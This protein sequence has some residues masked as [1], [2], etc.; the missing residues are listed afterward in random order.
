M[1][2]CKRRRRATPVQAA[3][4]VALDIIAEVNL[5]S[6]QVTGALAKNTPAPG[7]V[8]RVSKAG[9]PAKPYGENVVA[10]LDAHSLS[11]LIFNDGKVVLS[12]DGHEVM[13]TN[14]A[15]EFK[16]AQE[17]IRDV[18]SEKFA[19][20]ITVDQAREMNA[21]D[22]T[23]PVPPGAAGSDIVEVKYSQLSTEKKA[24]FDRAYRKFYETA[25]K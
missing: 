9:D 14:L 16:K 4:I 7:E 8:D 15:K 1:A 2:T 10:E 6:N 5:T 24:L 11:T 12:T 17:V 22:G 13:N 18:K 20:P 19:V 3:R 23:A 21:V 25:Q